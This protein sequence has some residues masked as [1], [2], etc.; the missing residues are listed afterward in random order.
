MP[1]VPGVPDHAAPQPPPRPEPVLNAAKLGGLV[2][3][4][5]TTVAGLIALIVAGKAGDVNAL[6]VSVG[7]AVTA[8]AA[9]VAYV[10]PVWQA[11]KA[12]RQVTPLASP[13]NNYG[14]SLVALPG[15]SPGPRG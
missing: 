2:A 11:R 1:D 14:D 12:R 13:R 10:A 8:V 15:V 4:A 3:A 7:A 9:L 6:G 5:V